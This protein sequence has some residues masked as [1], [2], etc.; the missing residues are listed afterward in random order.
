[1]MNEGIRMRKDEGIIRH[2]EI[3]MRNGV[4]SMNI[5]G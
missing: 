3:E 5:E 2:G 4:G 1:M